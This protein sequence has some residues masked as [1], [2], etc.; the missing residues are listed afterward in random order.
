MHFGV[1]LR[2]PGFALVATVVLAL[3]I[4]ATTA[5]FTLVHSLLL[6]PLPYPDSGKLVWISSVP[7][8]PAQGMV[9][10]LGGIF[11]NFATAAGRIRGLRP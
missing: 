2:E 10:M 9:G 5:I 7:P 6:E 4:G 1:F 11:S 3:G 8:R